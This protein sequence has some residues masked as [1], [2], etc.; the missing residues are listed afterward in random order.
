MTIRSAVPSVDNDTPRSDVRLDIAREPAT[1]AEL[2]IFTV[3]FLCIVAIE[4]LTAVAR[5]EII[6]ISSATA[7]IVLLTHFIVIDPLSESEDKASSRDMASL[8]LPALALLPL[9]RLL[10][11]ALPTRDIPERYWF[12]VVGIPMLVGAYGL[13]RLLGLS[14]RDVGVVPVLNR[15]QLLIAAS[16]APL[17]VIAYLM[18]QPE[19]SY[20]SGRWWEIVIAAFGL[21]LFSGVLEELIFRGV[22]QPIAERAF[23]PLGIA[24]STVVFTATYLGEKSPL[25]LAFMMLVGCYFALATYRTRSI[26]GVVAAHVIFVV[27]FLVVMPNV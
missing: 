24:S 16:G 9:M 5:P 17:A 15:T 3:Y 6:G 22:L 2:L 19:T 18:I 20:S 4:V 25:L 1:R 21:A 12:F 11:I 8:L 7:V 27:G 13:A 14:L 23:G 10:S 26:V